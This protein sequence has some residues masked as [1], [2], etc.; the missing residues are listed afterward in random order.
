MTYGVEPEEF[1]KLLES[2]KKASEIAGLYDDLYVA[3]IDNFGEKNILDKCIKKSRINP[4]LVDIILSPSNLGYGRAHN[5]AFQNVKSKYHLILNPDVVIDATCFA[6][7][8]QLMDENPDI[9]CMTPSVVDGQGNFQ[10]LNKHYP[11]IWLLFLRGFA[12]EWLKKRFAERLAYYEYRE[13]VEKEEKSNV[14]LA[15]GC[16]ML[17]RMDVIRQVNGFDERY[18][19]YFEDFDLSLK[20]RQYGN[21]LY[22]PQCKIIHKGGYAS[23]KGMKHIKY[24]F[25]SAYKFFMK[26]GWKYI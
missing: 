6:N 1:S 15:S 24:F 3:I 20:I 11:S 13:I 18:F 5:V 2:I 16:F 21:I 12:P 8:I 19:M 22:N 14:E 4:K 26:N 17:C 23:S 7:A 10:Y 9:C 25:S